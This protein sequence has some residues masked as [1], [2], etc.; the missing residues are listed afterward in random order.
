M[1]ESG[2][3]EQPARGYETR[4]ANVRNLLIF[5]A[6]LC[7]LVV[8]GLVGSMAVLRYFVAHQGLGPPVSPFANSRT[9]PPEPRLQVAAPRDLKQYKEEQDKLLNSYGWVDQQNGIVRIPIDEA[10]NLLIQ[11][12]LPVRGAAPA[13][14]PGVAPA[15]KPA[16]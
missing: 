11:R 14:K 6:G 7:A 12:G 2:R 8:L 15:T 9:L 4:D 1:N 16:P 13:K 10:M 3:K 5:G